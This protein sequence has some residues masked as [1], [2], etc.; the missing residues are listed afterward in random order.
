[1]KLI[2]ISDTHN[3]HDQ[4]DIAPCDFLIHTGDF[5]VNGSQKE[6]TNFVCWLAAQPAKHKVFIAGN[7]DKFCERH[8][9]EFRNLI[10]DLKIHYLYREE[11]TIEGIKFYGSPLQKDL[12]FSGFYSEDDSVW[13]QI[14]ED[15]NILLTHVP[16]YGLG[17]RVNKLF[18]GEIDHHIG[19][20]ALRK[21][22]ETLKQCGLH[23]FGHIHEGRGQYQ[24]DNGITAIN[25]ST[26]D[27]RYH[28]IRDPIEFNYE[29]N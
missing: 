2:L 5:T 27:E 9:T 23:I 3:I 1:M 25:A 29:K 12:K 4:L 11:I 7:H 14:P 19:N 28:R 13:N 22:V 18:W 17:D 26:L 15:V 16:P 6:V 20:K 21:K 24:Y 10:K 8:S